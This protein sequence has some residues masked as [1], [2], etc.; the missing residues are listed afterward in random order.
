MAFTTDWEE[1]KQRFTAWW[2]RTGMDRPI[3]RLVARKKDSIEPYTY[4]RTYR[5]PAEYQMDIERQV[6]QF[7]NYCETHKFL[8][9]AYPNFILYLG[10]GSLAQ[11]LGCEPTFA[12][13]TVWLNECVTDTWH[14]YGDIR[15]NSDNYWWKKHLKMLYDAKTLLNGRA[16]VNIIDLDG[17]LD[18]LSAMRGPQKLCYDLVDCPEI[19]SNYIVQLDDIYFNFYETLYDSLKM[20]DGSS[21]YSIFHLWGPGR[22]AK[23][24]CDFSAMISPSMF[25]DIVVPSLRKQ[26]R[27]LDNSLYHL[28]GPE[29]IKHLDALLEIEEL[30]VIEWT[31]GAGKPDGYD[32]VWY[33]IYD[34]VINANKSLWI[35]IENGSPDLLIEKVKKLV[36]R[37]GS[38]Y[39]YLFLPEMDEDDA[40][41]FF[42]EIG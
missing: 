17:S 12:W 4:M 18:T 15:F 14:E 13:D 3:M 32:E 30:D 42:S 10:A 24:Q 5:S 21:F 41:R 27:R 26:C 31:P 22:T 33:P 40:T 39:L 38:K 28:D 6:F 23:I 34:K 16:P 1:I 11:Y 25:K 29:A 19:I 8:A 7:L 20:E 35:P 9:D 36:K 2:N 37:Y